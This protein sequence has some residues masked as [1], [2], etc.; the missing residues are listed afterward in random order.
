MSDIVKHTETSVAVSEENFDKI[1]STGEYLPRVQLMTGG[2]TMCKRG[3]FPTNHYALIK[4]SNHHDLGGEVDVIVLAWRPKAID[5]SDDEVIDCYNP[6]DP[7]FQDI[8]AR[9]TEANSG[10]MF[11]PDYLIY[12]PERETFATFLMGTKS[13]RRDA[14]KLKAKIPGPVTLGS[15]FIETKRYSWQTVDIL[16]CS[17]EL[18]TPDEEEAKHALDLFLN[19]KSTQRELVEEKASTGDR[20]V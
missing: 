12:I 16:T 11:G 15:K 2:S 6:E 13:S 8:M 18:P 19:P 3:D 5:T 10:C 1:L 7:I 4:D 9:S 17:D 20:E 14:P